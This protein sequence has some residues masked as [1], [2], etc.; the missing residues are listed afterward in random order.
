MSENAL[1]DS[2]TLINPKEPVVDEIKEIYR[3]HF[4]KSKI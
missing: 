2:C 4:L 3:N 1:Q